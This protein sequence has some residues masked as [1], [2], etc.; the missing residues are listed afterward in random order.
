MKTSIS[1]YPSVVSRLGLA[2][3]AYAQVSG[4]SRVP[5][6]IPYQGRVLQ[7]G[8]MDLP[9]SVSLLAQLGST[10]RWS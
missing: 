9:C 10:R 5:R 3:Y 4:S 6:L 8:P 1:L 2:V 7:N